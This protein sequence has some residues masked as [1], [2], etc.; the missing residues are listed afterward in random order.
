MADED[1]VFGD[2]DV[3]GGSEPESGGRGGFLPEIVIRI[4][5]LV[6]MGLAAIIFIV[7]V[8]VVTMTILNR[9]TAQQSLPAVSEEYQGIEPIL[10]WWDG[11]EE[12]R[13]RTAD[14]EPLTVI[15]KVKIGFEKDNKTILTELNDRQAPLQAMVRA[16]FSKKTAS[17]LTPRHEPQITNE[18]ENMINDT[19]AG[20]DI[21]D[22]IIMDMQILDF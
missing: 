18:L 11:I 7:T 20:P 16:Y 19:L 6:A 5:K 12:I 22:V 15:V 8:V 9:G 4:L 2:D 14:A 13:T 17:E 3:T 1:V 21:T 10:Q